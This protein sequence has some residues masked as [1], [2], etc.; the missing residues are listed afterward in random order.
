MK[1][2]VGLYFCINTTGTYVRTSIVHVTMDG[3][4]VHCK[5]VDDEVSN[6][7]FISAISLVEAAKNVQNP[8]LAL[9]EDFACCSFFLVCIFIQIIGRL[10]PSVAQSIQPEHSH[11]FRVGTR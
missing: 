8:N 10:S 9:T 6:D 2:E 11:D 7:I 3:I 4:F 1:F 5:Y